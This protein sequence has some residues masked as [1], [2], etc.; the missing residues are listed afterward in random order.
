M[1]ILVVGSGGREH[2]LAWK[3]S[4]EAEVLCAPGNPGM[5]ER[6]HCFEIPTSDF[7]GIADLAV[8]QSVDL[9]VVGPE[10]PLID[11]LADALRARGLSVFGPGL[12]GARLEGS[13][14]FSKRLMMEAGVPTAGSE[15][16]ED[17]AL[18]H[19]YVRSRPGKVVVKA[20][21]AALGKGVLVTDS[22]EEAHEAVDAMLVER[23]FGDA[24]ATIVI[25]DR[26]EGREFSL[27]TLCSDAGIYSLPVAQDYKRALDNDRGPN[28]GGMGSF[29]PVSWISRDLVEE[30]EDR[31]VRPILQALRNRATPY[32]GV[33]FSGLMM[34]E[35]KVNCLEFNVRFGDPETQSV[36]RRLGLGLAG[37]LKACADGQSIPPPSVEENAVVT[38]VAASGGYPGEYEKGK[39]ISIGAMPEGVQVFHAGTALR[40][41]RLVTGG[42]RV[43]AVSAAAQNI[44]AARRLAYEGVARIGFE[45]MRFRA[46]IAAEP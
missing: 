26:L 16:F 14:A 30:T 21:G 23:E 44:E 38:V 43:L 9:V 2:A 29:S 46:D 7:Q 27:L 41:G 5:A 32:R 13:K 39:E 25:E 4:Q 10:A 15:V 35:G 22:E 18:A 24:G 28:T 37:A 12:E 3:L 34:H 6:A 33:L 19:E 1:R 17:P 8:T 45:G 42:G 31:V 40:D 11:G 20:S 36:V